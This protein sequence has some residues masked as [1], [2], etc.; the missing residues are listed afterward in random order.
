M[1]DTDKLTSILHKLNADQM[2]LLVRF[3]E[4]I[5]QDRAPD[6]LH[7]Q[8][9]V[10]ERYADFK[11]FCEASGIDPKMVESWAEETR[12]QLQARGDD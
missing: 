12:D 7:D 1:D 11:Q 6:E 3:A 8:S 9:D 4:F 2:R 10:R 5:T